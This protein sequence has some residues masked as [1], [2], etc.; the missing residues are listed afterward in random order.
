[1]SFYS[2]TIHVATILEPRSHEGISNRVGT[3]SA[4]MKLKD[5][6]STRWTSNATLDMQWRTGHEEGVSAHCLASL[7]QCLKIPHLANRRTCYQSAEN[8]SFLRQATYPNVQATIRADTSPP[9][10]SAATLRTPQCLRQQRRD[11]DYIT[12]GR[13]FRSLE[14]Q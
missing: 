11:V 2:L 10:T 8:F 5:R 7:A 3:T 1:M 9:Q 12:I 6:D 13:S 14:H 4:A